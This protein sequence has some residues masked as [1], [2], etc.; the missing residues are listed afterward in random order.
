VSWRRNNLI[1]IL[2]S[3]LIIFSTCAK[4]KA[5]RE[6][7]EEFEKF[8]LPQI[9]FT[10]PTKELTIRVGLGE[11]NEVYLMLEDSF[12]VYEGNILK[13]KG[14]K[15]PLQV[16]ITKSKPASFYYYVS[17]GDYET[18]SEALE[19]G[20]EIAGNGIKVNVKEIGMTFKTKKGTYS[21]ISYLVYQGPFDSQD[22]ALRKSSPLR[23]TIFKE[24]KTP[25]SGTLILRFG[26]KS[27]EAHDIIKIVSKAPMKIMN[28]QRKNLYYGGSDR[29]PFLA[30]GILEV[31]PSNSG[32]INVINELPVEDYVEG[33]LKGEVPLSFPKEALKAQAVA[34]RTNAISTMKKK[35]TLF[36]EPFDA[37]AD[38]FTQNYEGFNNN[39]YLKS[40]VYETRGEVITYQNKLI[41]VFY[42]SSCG[43]ALASSEE[44]FGKKLPYY[45]A[46]RDIYNKDNPL[47]LYS[48]A[49][50]RNFIDYPTSANCN[51]GNRYF[52]W[53]RTISSTELSLNIRNKF[54]K[55]LGRILDVKVTKRGPSGRAQV[56]FIEGENGSTFIEGDFDI[57]R[58]LDTNMLPS[59][60]FYVDKVGDI[61]VIR[62][63]GFGHGVG[64]C[65]Y[66]AARLASS[67]KSYKEILTFYFSGAQVEKIY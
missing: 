46:R 44:I 42:H 49:D 13:Y 20:R 45:K 19:K 62:G 25:P 40:I 1:K 2:L 61:F 58:A 50:V 11:Y 36:S 12:Y 57:R 9:P 4:R 6:K 18:L 27:Y 53:E 60:L 5:V 16:T 55:S 54:G 64:M 29:K 66:G 28:F 10:W 23:K 30:G 34:A 35:L 24:L 14:T 39:P 38:I 65:Q 32:K 22:E 43:G 48:D 59:S 63:A 37:T 3:I 26:D 15:S 31:R 21:T 56:V 17:Y 8:E 67:G 41:S 47:Y 7:P 52:R 51:E 33:V